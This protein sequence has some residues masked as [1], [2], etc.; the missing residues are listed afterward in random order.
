[1]SRFAKITS[2]E[3]V[4][5]LASAMATFR[6]EA[7][8]ALDNLDLEIRRALRWMQHDQKEYWRHQVRQGYNKVAEA[9]AELDRAMTYRKTSDFTPACRE[10]KLLLAKAKHRLREAEEKVEVV[11]RWSHE[12]EHELTEYQGSINQLS[13]WLQGDYPRA[14]ASLKRMM[15]AIDSYLAVN[16]PAVSPSGA[17]GGASAPQEQSDK[18]EEAESSESAADAANVDDSHK[19]G[20]Q[21]DTPAVD[22]AEQKPF[23]SNEQ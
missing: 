8:N 22:S 7:T 3:A 15:D 11:K 19:S 20:E 10:E 21:P 17:G 12:I 16:A 5:R 14:H 4:E 13:G 18:A 6:D 1:M 9:Q 23:R 2:V